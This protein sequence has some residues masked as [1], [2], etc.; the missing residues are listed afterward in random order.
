[1]SSLERTSARPVK[2]LNAFGKG[3]IEGRTKYP[4]FEPG[5]AKNPRARAGERFDL[6][7]RSPQPTIRKKRGGGGNDKKLERTYGGT[8]Q[9]G[10]NSPDEQHG[11]NA[12]SGNGVPKGAKPASTQ[13]PPEGGGEASAK[14]LEASVDGELI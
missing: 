9:Q 13:R 14:F 1:M 3:T 6:V 10:Q 2:G 12:T 8:G 4:G 7:A 5:S 11:S